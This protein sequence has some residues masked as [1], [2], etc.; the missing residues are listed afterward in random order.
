MWHMVVENKELDEREV[1]VK[2]DSELD[3]WTGLWTGL[4]TEILY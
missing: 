1:V 3:L 4:W 2:L